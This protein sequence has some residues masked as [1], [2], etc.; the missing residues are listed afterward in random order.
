MILLRLA[1]FTW[2]LLAVFA[3]HAA[4]TNP[5]DPYERPATMPGGPF[6]NKPIDTSER[7]PVVILAPEVARLYG[8]KDGE[9]VIANFY[10]QKKHWIAKLPDRYFA[11]I[12]Q[13]D[14]FPPNNTPVALGHTMFRALAEPG[15]EILL[16]PQTVPPS[17]ATELPAPI[18][19]SEMH[20]TADAVGTQGWKFGTKEALNKELVIVLRAVDSA[21][22]ADTKVK[23]LNRHVT[24]FLAMMPKEMR[25]NYPKAFLELSQRWGYSK[26]YDLIF[27]NCDNVQMCTIDGLMKNSPKLQNA[28]ALKAID[29]Y[30]L[31]TEESF[32][33]RKIPTIKLEDWDQE[34]KSGR[35]IRPQVEALMNKGPGE[36][37]RGTH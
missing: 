18:K 20:L 14:H 28:P 33:R 31:L 36:A 7:R 37:F 10:S 2:S 25:N 4:P 29:S 24:Q 26:M 16:Y 13:I 17:S 19:L 11:I 8:A 5:V 35:S 30:P 1:T 32:R 3:A 27:R 6:K 22:M 15:H 12:P 23:K 9:M 34:I 21:E